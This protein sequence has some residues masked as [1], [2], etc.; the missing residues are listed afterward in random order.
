MLAGCAGSPAPIGNPGASSIEQVLSHHR[1]FRY[2]GN[3]Q[4]F[5]VPAGVTL[6]AV[7][8]RAAGGGANTSDGQGGRGGGGGSSYVERGARKYKSRQGWK[9]A[10]GNGDVVVSW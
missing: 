6:I 4:T 2:T 9:D 10:T 5:K 3:E 7:D 8:A 1:T